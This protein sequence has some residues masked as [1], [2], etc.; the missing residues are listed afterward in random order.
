M[1]GF[2]ALLAAAEIA[3]F[4][5]ICAASP[6]LP[7]RLTALTRRGVVLFA[8]VWI[9]LLTFEYW[10]FGP[11]SVV[12]TD[13]E[14][15]L[16][17]P[18]LKYMVGAFK[19]GLYAHGVDGGNDVLAMAAYGNQDLSLERGLFLLLPSWAALGLNKV[20]AVTVAFAGAYL[21]ARRGGGADRFSAVAIAAFH[22]IAHRYMLGATLLQGVGLHLA[23]L[24][25]YL[26]VVRLERR[27]Y[28][29]GVA[30]V[31]A[32]H[33]VSSAALHFAPAVGL[34]AGL[35]WLMLGARRPL[36]FLAALTILI[37]LTTLNWAEVVFAMIQ[38]A[39]FASLTGR[40]MDSDLIPNLTKYFDNRSPESLLLILA[41]VA[42]L[43][44][45]HQPRRA[46]AGL[47]GIGAAWLIGP[48]LLSVPWT[49]LH[50]AVLKGY[51]WFYA[52]LALPALLVLTGGWAARAAGPVAALAG[53]ARLVA[54]AVLFLAAACGNVAWIKAYNL[55]QWLG[56]GGQSVVTLHPNLA[57]PDWAPTDHLFRVVTVPYRLSPN[58]VS[59][60]G[61]ES[62]DGFVTNHVAGRTTF[63][64]Y[65]VCGERGGC[66]WVLQ[67]Y[68]ATQG[69]VDLQCCRS[70]PAADLLPPLD[71]LRAGNV[72]YVI[73]ALPIEGLEPVSG[74][75]P[76]VV[77]PRRGD[78]LGERLAALLRLIR[79]PGPV[80]VYRL[81]DP[82][83]RAFLAEGIDPV[84]A[85][86]DGPAWAAQ[87][88]RS[89]MAHRLA[90]D[91]AVAAALP[92]PQPGRVGA[93]E[94]IRDGY[95]IEVDLPAGG[96]L[97]LNAPWSPFW[98]AHGDDGVALPVAAANLIHTVITVPPGTHQVTLLYRRP[99]LRQILAARLGW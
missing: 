6:W 65:A 79:E 61:F 43:A 13:D 4:A 88:V 71:S 52:S 49:T 37:G 95:R 96:L 48:L 53:P 36:R 20:M 18:L 29:T 58:T 92:A 14:G 55:G 85:D 41:A 31:A 32:L 44:R 22:T 98:Q 27:W 30:A 5:V 63:W 10:G 78:P 19:G 7:R 68:V 3:A 81:P 93:V 45:R 24:V 47:L 54:P 40:E 35:G 42:W 70:Y 77:P 60:Y 16:A 2:Y 8:L 59:A 89:A 25:V 23:P 9:L 86:S 33:A 97:V 83:P 75:G 17:L 72:E 82:L 74:P 62:F 66:P 76:E 91:P 51:D 99:L 34:A 87:A 12:Q 64:R 50:L 69:T 67:T 94:E 56:F 11:H 57:Q 80:H 28:F 1:T 39:P 90:V 26:L 73:S 84:A 46:I 15:E 21:L 38:T